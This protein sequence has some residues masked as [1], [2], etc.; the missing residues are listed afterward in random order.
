MTPVRSTYRLQLRPEFAFDHAILVLDHLERL[1]I[2]HVYTSP[3]LESVRGSAHGYD[4]TDHRHVRQEL[5][6]SDGLA[7]FV[8]EL[9]ARDMG[10]IV[11]IVPN[12]VSVAVPEANPRW[13]DLLAHGPDAESEPWFDVDWSEGN[14]RVMLPVLGDSLEAEID[15]G[16]IGVRARGGDVVITYHDFVVPTA[17]GTATTDDVEV[18]GDRLRTILDAQHHRLSH[19]RAGDRNYRVFFDI[20]SLA[21]IR[22]EVPEVFEEVH[23]LLR[24]WVDADLVD[25]IRVD[26]VDGLADPAAYLHQLRDL[27]G[28]DRAIWVEKILMADEQLPSWPVDGTTGYEFARLTTGLGVA[29]SAEADFDR[30]WSSVGGG[31]YE[32]IERE[33]KRE[34]LGAGLAPEL[35]RVVAA[36]RPL[37]TDDVEA[38]IAEVVV[39]FD[40]YRTYG[41]AAQPLSDPD[42]ER[43]A[44]AVDEAISLRPDLADPIARIA[45]ALREPDNSAETDFRVRFQQ[46]TGPAMAKAAEDTAFYRH[47]RL[48]ALD[49]VGGNPADFGTDSDALFGFARLVQRR[50]PRTMLAASTHDTKRSAD[51]RARLVALTHDPSAWTNAVGEWRQRAERLRSDLVDAA[52]EYLLWQTLVG[53]WPIDEDRLSTYMTKAMREA[54][55]STSWTDVDQHYEDAIL[56]FGRAVLSDDELRSSIAAFA[57]RFADVGRATRL[58]EIVL[59]L[60]FPGVPDTYQGDQDW[61]FDLVDPDNRRPVDHGHLERRLDEAAAVADVDEL[62]LGAGSLAKLWVHHRLLQLRGEHPEWFGDDV[63]VVPLASA[64]G[65]VAF[66]RGEMLVAVDPRPGSKRPVEVSLPTG[67]WRDALRREHVLEGASS[68]SEHSLWPRTRVSVLAP[69]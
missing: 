5:G 26:H 65:V 12:H 47:H 22:V 46:L 21:A 58:T 13:W 28:P 54:G 23:G 57:D 10:W 59:R 62:G 50:W 6:G 49:E 63:S 11:D 68:L 51:V 38:A 41:T 9:R 30:L 1:G 69:F 27:V 64:G 42:R 8:D 56:D 35:R 60:T 19:W 7:R 36:A 3:V 43:L 2:S 32:A 29:P 40:A 61:T 33:A 67:R 25:G 44:R 52:T 16:A 17:P 31:Q 48:I 55:T 39:A 15:R 4:V 14:G 34:V 53:A 66:R 24:S 45:G 18:G 37:G 20:D